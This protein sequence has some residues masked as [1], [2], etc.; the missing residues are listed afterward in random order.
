M[1]DQNSRKGSSSGLFIIL[2]IV[3]IIGGW[4]FFQ[5]SAPAESR[6]ATAAKKEMLKLKNQAEDADAQSL[7]AESFQKAINYSESGDGEFDEGN[8]TAAKISYNTAK[9]FFQLSINESKAEAAQIKLSESNEPM[10]V[11]K[12]SEEEVPINQKPFEVSTTPSSEENTKEENNLIELTAAIKSQKAM[13]KEKEAAMIAA[14]ETWAKDVWEEGVEQE[15]AGDLNL[16]K[17]TK[18]GYSTAKDFYSIAKN[19]YLNAKV[20]AEKAMADAENEKENETKRIEVPE[21]KKEEKPKNTAFKKNATEAKSAMKQKKQLV[22]GTQVEKESSSTYKMAVNLEADAENSY[23]NGEY[24]NA[25]AIYARAEEFYKKASAEVER[26]IEEKKAMAAKRS[27]DAERLKAKNEIQVLVNE[28]KKSLQSGDLN[29]LVKAKEEK[30]SWA[31]FYKSVKN[32]SVRI[33]GQGEKIFLENGSAHVSFRVNMSYQLKSK[34][35][36][37]KS[38]FSRDWDLM[39]KNGKWVVVASHFN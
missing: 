38:D 39:L 17:D 26:M 37:Q 16:L 32:V 20:K 13:L 7:A 30:S 35:G 36:T 6:P 25:S 33:N 12:T 22:P 15:K 2:I 5:D 8:Y 21:V 14:S 28:F 19:L 1:T 27:K 31:E 23:R 24:Q 4:F 18:E 9:G 3:A 10:P 34:K 11:A 29:K